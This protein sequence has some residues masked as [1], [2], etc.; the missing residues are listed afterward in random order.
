MYRIMWQCTKSN[1]FGTFKTAPCHKLAAF[2]MLV[3]TQTLEISRKK[4]QFKK[5]LAK[6][7]TSHHGGL[8]QNIKHDAHPICVQLI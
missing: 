2:Q 4:C 5:Y 1:T 8:A 3:V 7:V 6:F